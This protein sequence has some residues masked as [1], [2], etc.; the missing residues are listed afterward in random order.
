VSVA[1]TYAEAL[2]EAA[3]ERGAVE[4]IAGDLYLFL[5]AMKETPELERVLMSPEVGVPDKKRTVA[6]V[7]EGADPT[8]RNFLQVVIDRGRLE[9]I[10]DIGAAYA[11]RASEAG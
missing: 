6:A 3:E 7:L 8:L 1:V 10:E 4:R 2:F 11:Q 9:D 5:R